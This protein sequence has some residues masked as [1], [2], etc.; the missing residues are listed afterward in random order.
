MRSPKRSPTKE[1]V[2]PA[3]LEDEINS[4]EKRLSVQY[5][6]VPS[7]LMPYVKDSRPRGGTLYNPIGN[8]HLNRVSEATRRTAII[9]SKILDYKRQQFI[10]SC[11]SNVKNEIAR[12]VHLM[13]DNNKRRIEQWKVKTAKSPFNT[14]YYSKEVER[15]RRSNEVKSFKEHNHSIKNVLSSMTG[16]PAYD[17]C[18]PE[19]IPKVTSNVGVQMA[20]H[21]RALKASQEEIEKEKKVLKSLIKNELKLI[22]E[23]FHDKIPNL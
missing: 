9:E 5:T 11:R 13:D 1:L 23:T 16:K 22:E 8:F 10:T 21:Y 20:L 14:D 15:E 18:P 7:N 3:E 6:K 2:V 4:I 17:V 12:V 19:V